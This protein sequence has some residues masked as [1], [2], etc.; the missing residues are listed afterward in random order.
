MSDIGEGIQP[1]EPATIQNE[2][3]QP[4]QN[5]VEV[6][7]TQQSEQNLRETPQQA[8]T[9]ELKKEAGMWTKLRDV[10][11]WG[12]KSKSQE[13]PI[14]E[15]SLKTEMNRRTFLKKAAGVTAV[16][17]V[18]AVSSGGMLSVPGSQQTASEVYKP[19]EGLTYIDNT[20]FLDFAPQLHTSGIRQSIYPSNEQ[21]EQKILGNKYLNPIQRGIEFGID[22]VRNKVQKVEFAKTEA[23]KAM[24]KKYPQ[25]ALLHGGLDNFAT[26]GEIV[27]TAH[28]KALAQF[29]YDSHPI[30]SPIQ[31]ALMGG[32]SG[33]EYTD[34]LGNKGVT[35]EVKADPLIDQLKGSS[36]KIV[37][38]SF[39]MG[40]I[41]LVNVEKDLWMKYDEV[42]HKQLIDEYNKLP[43]PAEAFYPDTK[44]S[45]YYLFD[46]DGLKLDLYSKDGKAEYRVIE[47]ATG[48]EVSEGFRKISQ[49]QYE[50]DKEKKY[51]EI[52]AKAHT[53][54]E[55][56]K[57]NIDIK[58][59]GAYSGEEGE[60]NIQELFKLVDAF[61]DKLF[62][63]A[64]GNYS[65]D[66]R[67]LREKFKDKWPKNLLIV[68]QWNADTNEPKA[69]KGATLGA[70]IYV[71][72]KD[73]GYEEDR[74][75]SSIST[76]CLSGAANILVK[77]GYSNEQVKA[78]LIELTTQTQYET[79]YLDTL[80][81]E[82]VDFDKYIA[83]IGHSQIETARVFNYP[84]FQELVE[85]A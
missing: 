24:L 3:P 15:P 17:T 81:F 43:P 65:D 11:S 31:N 2:S 67:P 80:A 78:K 59:K 30:I 72:N 6:N 44:T 61:E 19:P 64:A 54:T 46:R 22:F 13:K 4:L 76:A 40:K 68:G 50:V 45:D 16:A 66:I 29:G 73:F 55:V 23:A 7:A 32:S 60:E 51:D 70:D 33:L 25:F 75:F 10:L 69:D 21:I 37:S 9:P 52:T 18:A 38:M 56:H 27:T 48:I 74:Q 14:Q 49:E 26:H 39:Q 84:R 85:A 58:I 47:E 8:I 77:K 35:I 82:P 71:D 53:L 79:H 63:V 42:K 57:K 34:K 41:H 20:R 12:K 28:R 62:I 1:A 83:N 5:Q 36:E